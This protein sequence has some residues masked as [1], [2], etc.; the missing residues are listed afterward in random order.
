MDICGE[1][2]SRQVEEQMH[3]TWS[4]K[5]SGMFEEQQKAGAQWARRKVAQDEVCEAGWGQLMESF[6]AKRRSTDFVPVFMK[7][8]WGEALILLIHFLAPQDPE[9]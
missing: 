5:E 8:P 7:V 3:S 9:F 2:N 4:S 6:K 1:L